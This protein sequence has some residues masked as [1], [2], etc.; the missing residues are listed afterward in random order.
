MNFRQKLLFHY[1]LELLSCKKLNVLNLKTLSMVGF[2][3]S[4]IELEQIILR[5]YF[6]G[7]V[8]ASIEIPLKIFNKR[9]IFYVFDCRW[10]HYVSANFVQQ[11]SWKQ[12]KVYYP[13]KI[14]PS[15]QLIDEA[16]F[17]STLFPGYLKSPLS[18]LKFEQFYSSWGHLRIA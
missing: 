15:L 10:W 14:I 6:V 12:L 13:N 11:N 8:N 1:P 5:T 4:L 9:T 3:R 17:S 18:S 16:I 7:P 2:S